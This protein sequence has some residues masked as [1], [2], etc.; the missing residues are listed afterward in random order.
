ML[1][2][3]LNHA[4]VYITFQTDISTIFTPLK[5]VYDKSAVSVS[6]F[7]PNISIPDNLFRFTACAHCYR[8]ILVLLGDEWLHTMITIAQIFTVKRENCSTPQ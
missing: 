8:T 4:W 1:D 7:I 2:D 6:S 5:S 3:I